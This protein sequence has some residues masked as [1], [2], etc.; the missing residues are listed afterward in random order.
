MKWN[1]QSYFQTM[2]VAH[3]GLPGE[4]VSLHLPFPQGVLALPALWDSYSHTG[5]W[6]TT[7]LNHY[8]QALI[9]LVEQQYLYYRELK[10]SDLK[11]KVED[12]IT[13]S[14]SVDNSDIEVSV[15]GNT[16]ILTGSVQSWHQKEEAGR[17]ALTTP[18]T[19]QLINQLSVDFSFNR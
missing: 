3:S 6:K 18:G 5:Q 9:R 19:R 15:T 7:V 4:K 12:Y 11:K 2:T 8:Y 10:E 13:R 1:Q 16:V 17:L 14:W